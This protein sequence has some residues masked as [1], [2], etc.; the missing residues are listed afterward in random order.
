[1]PELP[2]IYNLA[3]QMNYELAGKTIS[4][5]QVVQEKCLNVAACDFAEILVGGRVESATSKGKW[6]VTRLSRGDQGSWLLFN[7]GMGGNVV[8]HEDDEALPEKY[9]ARIDF[10]DGRVLTISFWWFG[11]IHAVRDG[12]LVSHKMTADLG[13][14]PLRDPGF[15]EEH[16]LGLLEGRR[17]SVKSFLTDQRNVAGIGNVYIQDMLF[18]ARMHPNRRLQTVTDADKSLLYRSMIE[19]LEE[20]VRL[21]GLAYENDLHGRAGGFK[22]F[23]VGYREGKPCPACG[24]TIQKVKTGSTASY[25]CP[26][27]QRE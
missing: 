7:L 19:T 2:E 18:R 23:L 1:V 11:Y 10:S 5:V 12:E 15:T 8:L 25:I 9:Q 21:G 16:F 14:T 20:S 27:C 24:A 26:N 22:D 4:G 3:D 6:V 17:G 13:L